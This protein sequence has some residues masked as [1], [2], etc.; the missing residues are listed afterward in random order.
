MTTNIIYPGYGDPPKFGDAIPDTPEARQDALAKGATAFTTTAFEFEPVKDKQEPKRY[1]NLILDIDCRE[2]WENAIQDARIIVKSL[3]SEYGVPPKML[4]YWLSGNKGCHIEI[5][6]EIFGG[7]EGDI[8]LPKI[9]HAMASSISSLSTKAKK[10]LTDLGIYNMGKGRLL[11]HENV[12]RAN[13]RYKVPVSYEEFISLSCEQLF[14]LTKNP[15]ILSEDQQPIPA[16]QTRLVDFYRACK[17]NVLPKQRTPATWS[18]LEAFEACEFIQHCKKNSATLTEPEWYAMITNMVAFGGKDVLIHE[19]SKGYPGYSKSETDAKI[20]HARENGRAHSCDY[21]QSLFQ[22]KEPCDAGFPYIRGD[23]WDPLAP[24]SKFSV[25]TDGLY[26]N[27]RNGRLGLSTKE[28]VCSYV[29]V[30]AKCRNTDGGGWGRRIRLKAP[31]G[32]V[33]EL[34]IRMADIIQNSDGLIGDLVNC[35]LELEPGKQNKQRLIE[36][37]QVALT[38]ILQSIVPSIGWQQGVY[39]LPDQA[40]GATG[41]YEYV[42]ATAGPHP[43]GVQGTLEEWQREIGH[44]IPGNKLLVLAASYAVSGTLLT[45]CDMEGMGLHFYGLSSCGKT[46]TMRVASSICGGGPQGYIRA[47]R[48]T[49]N[50]LESVAVQH[51]DNLLC[52]DEIGQ[53][54]ERVVSE[55]AYMLPN[56]QG[57]GR[58]R[59]SGEAKPIARWKVAFMSTGEHTLDNKIQLSGRQTTMAGQLVR[60]LDIPADAGHGMGVFS[61]LH[62]M[63]SSQALSDHLSNSSAMLYG[64]PMREFLEQL[65]RDCPTHVQRVKEYMGQFVQHTECEGMSPQIT[66]VRERFALI[67]AAGELAIQ[68]GVLPLAPGEAHDAALYYFN[69]WVELRGGTG[70]SEVESALKR[71]QEFVDLHCENRFINLDSDGFNNRIFGELAGYKWL[72][73]REWYYLIQSSV[74]AG[75]CGNAGRILILQELKKR[76][77]VAMNSAGKLMETKNVS[78]RGNVRGVVVVPSRWAGK[79]EDDASHNRTHAQEKNADPGMVNAEN[80]QAQAGKENTVDDLIF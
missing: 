47:W 2:N 64:T 54:E 73:N 49:D 19:Y 55:V 63:A 43:F 8:Y 58:A 51:N 59:K 48:T 60:V 67:A 68:F 22:C 62:G 41:A 56:G 10:S 72:C 17:E 40:Y 23:G 28:K 75:L 80:T 46:T 35:G 33:V 4:R 15:R 32:T 61:E 44:Y 27:I 37:L 53:A 7:E 13:G 74:F 66:R 25:R 26:I 20:R 12:L 79:P 30:L 78:G 6:A 1:G 3:E 42:Y 76:G 21:I 34:T 71:I 50:A 65:T 39:V 69:Q 16:Q 77:W 52:L 11:R 24:S 57:K 45:P 31:D 29:E 14:E 9:L 36:Y 70:D 5:P 18:A 38:S